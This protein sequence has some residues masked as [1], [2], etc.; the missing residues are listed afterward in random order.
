M[1]GFEP[2]RFRT[3]T[4]V[5]SSGGVRPVPA[6]TSSGAAGSGEGVSPRR[7]ATADVLRVHAGRG[8]ACDLPAGS[9][10]LAQP[11][12]ATPVPEA[13]GTRTG[14]RPEPA[15]E[16]PLE[17]SWTPRDPPGNPPGTPIDVARTRP[18]ARNWLRTP[19]A[20][21]SLVTGVRRG[22]GLR[23]SPGESV[24]RDVLEGGQRRWRHDDTGR[25][26]R[27]ASDSRR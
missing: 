6:L 13:N 19:R 20:V 12:K 15:L 10:I 11:C 17:L 16:L 21:G 25:V 23:R 1:A 18:E 24:D 2:R 4:C 27:A 22:D 8:V 9:A 3:E 7:R 14:R 26:R 5:A